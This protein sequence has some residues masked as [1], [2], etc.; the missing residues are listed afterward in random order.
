M[1]TADYSFAPVENFAEIL[2]LF[3]TARRFVEQRLGCR[4]IGN[5]LSLGIGCNRAIIALNLLQ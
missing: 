1:W 4:V 5:Y 3:L 2:D